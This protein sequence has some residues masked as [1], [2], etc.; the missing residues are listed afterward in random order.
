LKDRN[1]MILDSIRSYVAPIE[2]SIHAGDVFLP[3]LSRPDMHRVFI[4]HVLRPILP[5]RYGLACGRAFSS[6]DSASLADSI[7][8]YDALHGLPLGSMIPC[9]YVYAACEVC[10]HMSAD[11]F[12]RAMQNI[13]STKTLARAKATAHDVSPTHH[14]G[15][16]GARYA[17]LS[18]DKLN[19]YLGL[20]MAYDAEPP[21]V[22]LTR[23]NHL[24]EEGIVRPENTPDLVVCFKC[25]WVIS[26]ATRTSE[27][28]VPRSSFAKFALW[29][30][31][32][33]LLAVI[34]LLLNVSLSQIQLR[35][36]DLM[37][38]L[39]ALTKRQ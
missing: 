21:D 34:Y 15:V 17:Q 30:M 4:Q 1:M 9:E 11:L 20:I 26:R 32:D 5:A 6:D 24:V 14:L 36:P 29:Q 13:A 3:D 2:H 28:G 16:F 25:G 18:D 27:M 35:G 8:I 38:S 22:L 12:G 19:P 33:N 39:A 37:R 7:M 31:N 23:L 10:Q